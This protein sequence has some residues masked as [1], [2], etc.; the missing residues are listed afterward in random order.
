METAVN[1]YYPLSRSKR[2]SGLKLP[3]NIKNQRPFLYLC[4]ILSFRQFRHSTNSLKF[5]F[6]FYGDSHVWFAVY[7][8]VAID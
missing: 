4:K 5:Y 7:F 2:L 6:N 3:T 1:N 8:Y